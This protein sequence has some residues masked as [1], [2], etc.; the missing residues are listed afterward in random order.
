[1]SPAF[2]LASVKTRKSH[3]AQPHM[4]VF[5]ACTSFAPSYGGPAVSVSRLAA[6]V[7][8][9]G[10]KVGLWAPDGSAATSCVVPRKAAG[11]TC[12][13]GSLDEALSAAG[14]P[15]VIHDN[16]LWLPHNHRIATLAGKR[17]IARIVSVRGMLEP[18]AI[19]HKRFKKAIAWRLYQRRDLE[20]ATMLHATAVS[21]MEA[22]RALGITST[23]V[24]IPN[25]ADLPE[26]SCEPVRSAEPVN[27]RL[28]LFLS[29]IHP[30]KGLPM[31]IEAWAR[32]RPA[33]WSLRIAG[34]DEG[35]HR[36]QVEDLVARRD[37]NGV[38]TFLGPV[39][40]E[41]KAATYRA[42][43]LFVL[44]TYSENFGMVVAEALAHGLP[45]LTTRGAPWR[46][47]ETERCGWWVESTVDG[48]HSGLAAAI[49]ARPEARVEM[50]RRGRA[51]I[52]ARYAWESIARRFVA[53]YEQ[54]AGGRTF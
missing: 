7:A 43:D 9:T 3:G 17:G 22:I 44:P 16:G 26:Q 5:I 25:G 49:A 41:D 24:E 23:I 42:A 8:G 14:T 4:K 32:L 38:V 31:L 15:D 54:A 19:R 21:E 6:A 33:G 2:S 45:V 29:R 46:E 13:G 30:K 51:L 1:M 40:G 36:A 10:A 18:W 50:G 52:A 28:A 20:R 37:L 53:V 12:L 27:G 11:M 35:G 34:P 39:E 47:L 48:V